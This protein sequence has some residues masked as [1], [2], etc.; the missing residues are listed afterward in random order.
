MGV[1]A[2]LSGSFYGLNLIQVI[3]FQDYNEKLDTSHFHIS[4]I[5]LKENYLDH[6]TL[7]ILLLN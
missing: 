7:Q 4:D 2:Y 6:N 1:M 3:H 5:T